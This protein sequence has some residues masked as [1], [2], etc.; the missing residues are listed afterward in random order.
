MKS[1]YGSTRR[2]AVRLASNV[3]PLLSFV[4]TIQRPGNWPDRDTFASMDTACRRRA[5]ASF[6]D[7]GKRAA[8]SKVV[9]MM[10][11][12]VDTKVAGVGTSD[13]EKQAQNAG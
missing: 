10:V 1:F 4:S 8:Q 7:M 6:G 3:T 11:S 2:S 13:S 12:S 9:K 5:T